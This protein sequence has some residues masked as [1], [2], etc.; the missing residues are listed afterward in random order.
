MDRGLEK[1]FKIHTGPSR[2]EKIAFRANHPIVPTLL[3]GTMAIGFVLLAQRHH[4][5]SVTGLLAALGT[6]VLL[7]TLV[8]YALHRFFFHYSLKTEPWRTLFSSLH[9]E[10]HRDTQDP[11]LILAPP[12]AAL[13]YSALIFTI[14]YGVTWNWA[15]ALLLLAG[16]DLGYIF[17]EWVHYGVHQF[18]WSRGLLGYYKRNHFH[19]HFTQPKEGFGVT[20]P[21]WDHIFKTTRRA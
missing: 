20:S 2:I 14:L 3:F 17:Y 1:Y 10:H 13:T 16:I 15:L 5:F 21:I 12:T 8:E 19:H 7:W 11:G 6:G 4:P 18:N 9:L